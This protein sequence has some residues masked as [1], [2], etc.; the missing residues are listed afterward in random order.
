MATETAKATAGPSTFK[1]RVFLDLDNTLYTY[2]ESDFHH[3][4]L[5][6][7]SEVFTERMTHL[8]EKEISELSSKY[9][10]QYGLSLAGLARHHHTEESPVDLKALCRRTNVCDYGRLTKNEAITGMLNKMKDED[11]YDLWIFTNADVPHAKSC[12]ENIGIQHLFHEHDGY[13]KCIDCLDQW[14]SSPHTHITNKPFPEAYHLAE[15]KAQSRF[16]IEND[17]VRV[18]VD[19]A[20]MNLEAPSKMGWITVWV[21]HGKPLPETATVEPTIIITRA[22]ELREALNAVIA[23]AA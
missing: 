11:G 10:V 18:M 22:E 23:K 9:H 5:Q 1:V 8:S 16:K 17:F 21:S 6:N 4:M 14:G 15:E 7:I 3:R 13:F 20:I 19:D 12:V 2:Q